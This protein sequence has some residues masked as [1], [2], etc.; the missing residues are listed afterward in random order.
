VI[1][2]ALMLHKAPA[3]FG[4]TSVL[5]KQNLSKRSAR[6]HLIVF[7]AA[8]PIGA[9]LTWAV[10]NMLGYGGESEGTEFATGV[11][12]LFSGGTFLYVAVHVMQESDGGHDHGGAQGNGY[13]QVPMGLYEEQGSAVGAGAKGQEKGVVDVL[14]TVLGMLLPLLTQFGHAH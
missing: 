13:A 11:L 9:L 7:S 3:A 1:F 4:L 5:L 12:L 14:V 6:G 8:A 10:V 2:L